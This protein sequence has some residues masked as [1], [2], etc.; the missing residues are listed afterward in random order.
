MNVN[1]KLVNYTTKFR[2]GKFQNCRFQNDV[3]QSATEV[4]IWGFGFF[5]LSFA[6][7]EKRVFI[8]GIYYRF[9]GLTDDNIFTQDIKDLETGVDSASAPA[10]AQ[11]SAGTYTEGGNSHTQME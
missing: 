5:L 9:M 6:C 3:R 8:T 2:T 1:S 10:D 7:L 11:G 4:R